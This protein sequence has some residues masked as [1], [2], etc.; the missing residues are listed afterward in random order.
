MLSPGRVYYCTIYHDIYPKKG[1]IYFIFHPHFEK[2][3]PL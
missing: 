3:I 1:R 2:I